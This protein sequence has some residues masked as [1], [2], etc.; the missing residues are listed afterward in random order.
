MTEKVFDEIAGGLDE[1]IAIARGEAAPARLH[2]ST[3][4]VTK[5]A[6]A[7]FSPRSHSVSTAC[8]LIAGDG[9]LYVGPEAMHR[10]H[11][12]NAFSTKIVPQLLPRM[13]IA[14]SFRVIWKDACV[15]FAAPADFFL[16]ASSPKGES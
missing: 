1:A 14:R 3:G 10:Q 4:A 2:V 16:A 6:F 13:R 9:G 15:A 8:S 12:P 11:C 7:A 5:A